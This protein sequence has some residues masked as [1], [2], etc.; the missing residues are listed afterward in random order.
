MNESYT[1]HSIRELLSPRVSK[2]SEVKGGGP[3][4]WESFF[5]RGIDI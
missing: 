2:T 3:K 1:K 4:V 5:S